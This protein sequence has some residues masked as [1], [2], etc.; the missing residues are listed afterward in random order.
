MA[1]S[2]FHDMVADDLLTVFYDPEEFGKTCMWEGVEIP[3]AEPPIQEVAGGA[4]TL[5]NLKVISC[6]KR[7]LPRVP[8]ARDRVAIDG[9]LWVVESVQPALEFYWITLQRQKP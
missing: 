8:E 3:F 6:R 7:D 9:T 4:G 1:D 5:E 2:S